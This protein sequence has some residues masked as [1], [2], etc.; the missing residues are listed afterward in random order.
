MVAVLD[1]ADEAT[2][3]ALKHSD[4]SPFAGTTILE[5]DH[6]SL[7]LARNEG[8]AAAS[9]SWIATAD[10]DDLISC[11]YVEVMFRAAQQLGQ[12]NI[13]IPNLICAFGASYHIAEYHDLTQVTPLVLFETHPFVSRVFFHRSLVERLQYHDASP[14]TTPYAYE[15]WHFAC[16]AVASGFEF[17]TAPLTVLFYRLREN[18]LLATSAEGSKRQIPPSKLFRPAEWLR[19][20]TPYVERLLT[21]GD[22]RSSVASIGRDFLRKPFALEL[23]AAANDIDPG[24]SLQRIAAGSSFNYLSQPLAAPLAYYELCR[25]AGEQQFDE[26]FLL[27]FLTAGG[28]D[29]YLLHL[30]QE[31]MKQRPNTRILVI[32]G[33]RFDHYAWLDELPPGTVC[34][35]LPKRFPHLGA[36]QLDLVCF[37][38]L[39]G[40]A[41]HAR[42]HIKSSEFSQ[43]FFARYATM[44]ADNRPV[45]YRFSDGRNRYGDLVLVEPSA[46]HF[47]SEHLEHLDRI[48][49]DNETVME[50]DVR[51]LRVMSS[52]WQ[53]LPARVDVPD[54]QPPSISSSSATPRQILW[55]SRIDPEK[56][57]TLLLQ[58]AKRL[59]TEL[60]EIT[61]EVYG[62]AT[63][64]SFGVELF[65]GLANLRYH[66]GF[67]NFAALRPESHLC[68]V[69]TSSFDGIP[70]VLLEV[71]S[72]GVPVIA[73]AVGAIPELIKD[74]QTGLLLECTG[75]DEADASLYVSAI[76]R[77]VSDPILRKRLR[78]TAWRHMVE[79]HSSVRYS[80]KVS[81]IFF[82]E[83]DDTLA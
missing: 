51:R 74:E 9:G 40:C 59:A 3:A 64:G 43:R 55:V 58:I 36:D 4:I 2:R 57:P 69:Y 33:Q 65:S 60:P 19:V 61:L 18:G 28:A 70:T 73:P 26:V 47:V 21:E 72:A 53:V 54:I 22:T 35:D 38:L 15:D 78:D 80:A 46:F 42:I 17:R 6:G 13:L 48:V 52:K 23:L 39:Q 81:Q 34:V 24:V 75:S 12:N 44:L 32:F 10:G 8:I 29:R 68:F 66:G 83:S 71:I 79:R 11:N 63:L 20:C 31:M 1:R 56:R 82:A 77:L 14:R 16:E 27:P 30:M 50:S 5:V 37:R 62:R 7:G 45:F 49:C 67:D 25:I 41:R 76:K